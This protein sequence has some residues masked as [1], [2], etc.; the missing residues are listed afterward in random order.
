[1]GLIYF[2]G[3]TY[4]LVVKA[5]LR[6]EFYLIYLIIEDYHICKMLFN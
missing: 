6:E 1:M 3:E 5:E 4:K 2:F